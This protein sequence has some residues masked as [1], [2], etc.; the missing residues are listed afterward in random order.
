M[1]PYFQKFF[2]PAEFSARRARVAERIGAGAI[3]VLPGGGE[4]GSFEFFRQ[5][6]EFFYL[7]GVEAPHA[8]LKIDGADAKTTLYLSARDAKHEAS[9]GPQLNCELH[10]IARSITGVDAIKP[11]AALTEDIASA[12][13]IFTLQQPCEGR[14]GCRD[15]ALF[16]RRCIAN[17]PWDARVSHEAHF[18]SKLAAAASVAE[19]LDLTPIL[20][21]LRLIK[22]PREIDAMRF[23]GKLSAHAAF[24]AMKSA[25]SGLYEFHLGAI[26]EYV[27]ALNGARGGSYR[28]IIA[29][30]KNI[31]NAHYYRN[32]CELKSGANVLFDYAPDFNYYTSDIGRFFPVNGRFDEITRQLYGFVAKF[33][34]A[35][36]RHI[37]PGLLP[38]EVMRN[39]ALE[40]ESTVAN[41][42]WLKSSYE[43]AARELLKFQGH[44]SH[45][46][47]MAVHDP[48]VYHDRPLRSG[49]VFALDPQLWVR[50]EELYIRVEDTVLVTEDGAEILTVGAPFEIDEIEAVVGRGGMLQNFPPQLGA[51]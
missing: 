45:P 24:E 1:P 13:K 26:A 32:D 34:L 31:W 25:R 14:Q 23:T 37:R 28:P 41:T 51:S 16:A 20:D 46:V 50:D 18:K 49:T 33:H 40:M 7:S 5:Y 48:S 35:L 12:K 44:L 29:S 4:R 38:S 2:L 15:T 22:S 3:A 27:Y 6:N 39:A 36:L 42:R 47:G 8:Y 11:L 21:D 9:E 17:D 30:G 19:F 43:T 10:D